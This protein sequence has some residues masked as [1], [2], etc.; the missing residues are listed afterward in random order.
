M[1]GTPRQH[2]STCAG[3][4]ISWAYLWHPR[5]LHVRQLDEAVA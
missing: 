5:V 4:T 1:S 2:Y 3:N